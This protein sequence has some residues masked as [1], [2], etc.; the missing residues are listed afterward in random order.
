MDVMDPRGEKLE[1]LKKWSGFGRLA[2]PEEIAAMVVFLVSDEASF[3][4][5]QNYAVCGLTNVGETTFWKS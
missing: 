1:I 5:G 2:K 3:I 4:T